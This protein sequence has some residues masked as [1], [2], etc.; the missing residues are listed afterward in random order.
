[1]LKILSTEK[2]PSNFIYLFIYLFS[3]AH[4]LSDTSLKCECITVKIFFFPKIIIIII[5]IIILAQ[6][7]KIHCKINFLLLKLCKVL[8]EIW[9]L[10]YFYFRDIFICNIINYRY[11]CL[12]WE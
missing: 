7:K 1:M 3:L 2:Q 9:Y 12:G 5:I 6:M 11:V 10:N 8:L 4:Y